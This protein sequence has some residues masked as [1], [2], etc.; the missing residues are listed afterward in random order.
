M[1][2]DLKIIIKIKLNNNFLFSYTNFFFNH[3][4]ISEHASSAWNFG[5]VKRLRWAYPVKENIQTGMSLR[6]RN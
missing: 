3:V 2:N 1:K 4:Q 6:Q 5:L